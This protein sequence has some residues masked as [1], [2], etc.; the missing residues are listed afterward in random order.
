MSLLTKPKSQTISKVEGYFV[1]LGGDPKT[2][3]LFNNVMF[4][5]GS[6][7]FSPNSF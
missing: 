7:Q 1:R 5:L 2:N 3:T 4:E 6:P